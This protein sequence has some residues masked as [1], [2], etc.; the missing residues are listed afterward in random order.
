MKTAIIAILV[1]AGMA[2]ALLIVLA[3]L[4][5]SG[6]P[7]GLVDGRL[8]AC[9][10]SPNCVCSEAY[11]DALHDIEP[12][13]VRSLSTTDPLAAIRGVITD[14]GGVILEEDGTY[15]AAAFSS[16]LFG[17]VDDL[18]VRIEPQHG[19]IHVRSASRAGYGDAGVN[20]K[21][22]ELL[23][24]LYTEKSAMELHDDS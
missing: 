11:G 5:R 4:S 24:K 13:A 15:L 20:R 8:S 22:V 18:E 7:P 14:M 2:L 16:T 12:V 23:R 19:V 9:P 3:A 10:D 6:K 1:L 17:F 21:R